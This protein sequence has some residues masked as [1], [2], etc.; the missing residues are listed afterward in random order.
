MTK[1]Q[2][3]TVDKKIKQ[4][5]SFFK[6]FTKNSNNSNTQNSLTSPRSD[7]DIERDV[8]KKEAS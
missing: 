7:D 1:E 3:P 8:S 4:K 6:F 5:T 2:I